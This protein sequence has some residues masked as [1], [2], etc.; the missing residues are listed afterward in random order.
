M[1]ITQLI[2]FSAS[3]RGDWWLNSRLF[4]APYENVSQTAPEPAVMNVSFASKF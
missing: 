2:V 3:A 1:H 4:E